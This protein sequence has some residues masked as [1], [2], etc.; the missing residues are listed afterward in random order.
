VHAV[1]VSGMQQNEFALPKKQKMTFETKK[2]KKF[3]VFQ[4]PGSKNGF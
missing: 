3:L 4:K 1:D 2:I